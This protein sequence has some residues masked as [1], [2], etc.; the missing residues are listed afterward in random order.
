MICV[1]I[2]DKS[3][4]TCLK[5]L[6]EVEMAEIRLDLSEYSTMEIEKVFSQS[7]ITIATCRAEKTGL[8]KQKQWLIK[9]I[10]SGANYVDIEIEVPDEQRK[11]IIDCAHK[12]NCKV[13]ISY[14]NF[15]ETPG[16]N[17]L[18]DIAEDCYKK[19]AEVA[20]IATMV[21]NSTDNARLMSLYS[22]EKPVVALGMGEL[23]KV[24]RIMSPLLG[25][26]FTFAA[27]DDGVIT[28]PGQITYKEM[29][30]I[31]EQLEKTIG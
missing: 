1:A 16:I 25:G 18:F 29:K 21:N 6:E 14:H 15:I 23:G 31:V 20:K 27:Q 26:E 11:A 8:E 17:K 19:G 4:D 30:F 28:A 24:T 2:S 13:I 12:N 9:A 22:L 5:I 7:T 3:S 10:E